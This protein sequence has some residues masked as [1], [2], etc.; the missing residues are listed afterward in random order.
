M[1]RWLSSGVRLAK[2]KNRLGRFA[3]RFRG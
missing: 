2:S 3:I 1:P